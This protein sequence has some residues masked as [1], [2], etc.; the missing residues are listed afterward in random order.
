MNID[1]EKIGVPIIVPIIAFSGTVIV[2][3]LSYIFNQ[4]TKIDIIPDNKN[5]NE[6]MV[7]VRN[8]G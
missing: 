1:W 3:F 7:D 8:E 4:D 5:R 2:G 6:G